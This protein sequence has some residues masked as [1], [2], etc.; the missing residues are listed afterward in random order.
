[1]HRRRAFD[2]RTG[3]AAHRSG[4][5]VPS[6][7]RTG[8]SDACHAGGAPDRCQAACGRQRNGDQAA[9]RQARCTRR[10]GAGTVQ[11][12]GLGRVL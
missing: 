4:G 9:G 6:V 2:G 1:S 10:S 8:S 5:P 3:A 7:G 11:R 12:V